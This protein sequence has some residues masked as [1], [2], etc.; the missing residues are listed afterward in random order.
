M[1]MRLKSNDKDFETRFVELLGLKREVSVDV[2]TA[3]RVIISDVR[4][5]GDA[6]YDRPDTEIRQARSQER[7]HCDQRRRGSMQ[8][9]RRARKKRSMH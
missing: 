7:W 4:A 9:M 8:R 3:V 2:D 5:R 6:A 1:T